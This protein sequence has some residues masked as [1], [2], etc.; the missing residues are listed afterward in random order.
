M[1]EPRYT[2]LENPTEFLKECIK[3]YSPSENE[4]PYARFLANFMK[5]HGFKVKFDNIGN[6]IAIKGRGKPF[7]LLISHMD[8]IPGELPVFE[9]EGK[10]FGRGA[11]DCKPSL[12]AMVYAISKYDFN[13]ITS[14][15]IAI[16]GIVR[17]ESSLEGIQEFLKSD[18]SPD[19]A[20]FGEPTTTSQICIGYKG[21]LCLSYEI[22]SMPGHMASSWM[23]VNAIEVALDLWN[24]IK[25]ISQKLSS[26]GDK[27]TQSDSYFH[28]VISNIGTLKGGDLAN[29][30]PSKCTMKIDIRFPPLIKSNL[31]LEKIRGMKLEIAK[32][33]QNNCPEF[34]IKEEILSQI[35][36]YEVKGDDV[37]TGALR[38]AIFKI[39]KEKAIMVKKTGT[40]FTN[41]IGTHFGIPTITYGPGDPKLEHTD[42]EFVEIDEYKEALEIY[43]KFIEKFFYNYQKIISAK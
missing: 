33:Y 19:F 31:L 12:A 4:T 20:I 38:W 24:E 17:E 13:T 34:Q 36:G 25:I 21:R 15:T 3:L 23:H 18:L 6:V 40:T 29:V 41:V 8:T 32:K 26:Q 30:I 10:I 22:T 7:L 9:K 28:K 27:N 11:V 16:V 43:Q 14:G 1:E 2:M 39:R 35:E 37:M 42:G 5:N